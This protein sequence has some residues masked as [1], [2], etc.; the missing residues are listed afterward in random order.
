MQILTLYTRYTSKCRAN[1]HTTN[2]MGLMF[3]RY[4]NDAQNV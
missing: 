4:S 2:I 3:T 1:F